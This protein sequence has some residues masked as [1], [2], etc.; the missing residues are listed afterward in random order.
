MKQCSG[1]PQPSLILEND[2][3][4]NLKKII[5]KNEDEFIEYIHKL[6]IDIKNTEITSNLQNSSTTIITLKTT[7]FKVDFNDN[8]VKI[9]PI[10]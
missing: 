5:S 3:S 10:K 6:G 2:E 1:K 8:F 7:C 9:T 4:N